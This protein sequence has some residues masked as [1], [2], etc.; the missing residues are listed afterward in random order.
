MDL[1]L[2][3]SQNILEPFSFTS[4]KQKEIQ[5]IIDERVEALSDEHVSL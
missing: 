1:G 4:E 5:A 3:M 2:I